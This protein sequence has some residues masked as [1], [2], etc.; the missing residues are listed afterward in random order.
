MNPEAKIL[1][2]EDDPNLGQ[3]LKD[4]LELKGYRTDLARDGERGGE[5]YRDGTYDLLILDVMM[6]K[7]DGFTLGAEIRKIDENIPIIFLTARSS[8]ED[9]IKGFQIG[10]DDYLSKP[11]STEEL[12][13]RIK[14]VLKRTQDT[15]RELNEYFFGNSRLDTKKQV[16]S[17]N[18]SAVSL[19]TKEFQLLS[20]LCQHINQT[21]KRSLLLEKI[22]H[23]DTY[24]NA[25]S[26]DVYIT[27][28]RKHLKKDGSLKLITVYGEGFKLV[29]L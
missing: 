22:W 1:L 12:L 13:M 28:L 10:G 9:R 6:P 2:V 14:A 11:F 7:K 21:V 25:R 3:L 19:T 16:L 8:E 15:S 18:G 17:T 5:L 26:M 29:T 24:F 4:Y 23:S 27:R 20:L